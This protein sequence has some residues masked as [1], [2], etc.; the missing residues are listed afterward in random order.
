ML[1]NVPRIITSWLPRRAPYWLK[2][3]GCTPWA[4]EVLRRRARLG[5]V[6][7]R[8]DVV[9]R[10]RVAEQRE[11]TR[12]ADVGHRARRHR[13]A[14]EVRRIAHVRGSRLPLVD[15]AF[16]HLERVPVLVAGEDARVSLLE[17]RGVDV[18]GHRRLD[19]LRRRPDVL[20]EDRL[21]VRAGAERLGVQ[22]DVHRA[23]E[24]VGHDQRRRG[25]EVHLHFRMH[26]AL[27]VAVAGQH[28]GRDD[29]AGLDAVGDLGLAAGRSCRCRSCS[30]SRRRRSRRSR[31]PAAGPPSSG[32]R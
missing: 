11:H 20:Q 6:A 3:T 27:E 32:S 4:I 23:G 25:E 28:G 12:A 16:R 30:R 13:H 2:S 24:R 10:D 17:H 15:L 14:V 19:L 18:R 29:V 8:R 9:G 21:A 31:D 7:G 1:A 26:A 22:V 5:D